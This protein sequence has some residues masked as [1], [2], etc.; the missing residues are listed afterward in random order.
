M[1]DATLRVDKDHRAHAAGMVEIA[2]FHFK[3]IRPTE[4]G[5][6]AEC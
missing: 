4:N 2:L 5:E 3:V 1:R 6:A